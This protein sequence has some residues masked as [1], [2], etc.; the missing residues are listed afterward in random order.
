[1]ANYGYGFMANVILTARGLYNIFLFASNCG[2]VS[3]DR[4]S[5][6]PNAHK[7]DISLKDFR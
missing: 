3:F 7:Q 6:S 1:M 2:G 4:G 5:T